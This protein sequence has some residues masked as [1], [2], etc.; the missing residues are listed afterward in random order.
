MNKRL[1]L[2]LLTGFFLFAAVTAGSVCAAGYLASS[3][4]VYGFDF[5]FNNPGARSNAMGGAFVGL[6]DDATAAYANPAGLPVLTL[7]EISIEYKYGKYTSTITEIVNTSPWQATD[8]DFDSTIDGPSFIS[9][10]HP[11]SK[12]TIAVFRHRLVDIK[13]NFIYGALRSS[14]DRFDVNVDIVADTLGLSAGMKIS[15]M[16]NLG[17]SIGFSEMNFWEKTLKYYIPT[18]KLEQ[19]DRVDGSD[20]DIHYTLSMLLSPIDALSVGVY[21]RQ[22][23]GFKFIKNSLSPVLIQIDSD[24]DG[25]LDSFKQTNVVDFALDHEI[26]VPDSYGIGIAYRVSSTL[27]AVLDLNYVE[28]SDLI[29]GMYDQGGTIYEQ[30]F[31]ID[32]ALDLHVGFEYIVDLEATPLALRCGYYYRPAHVFYFSDTTDPFYDLIKKVYPE[33][34]DEHI[35]SL[36]F[37]VLLSHDV[38]FDLA[39]SLGKLTKEA[40]GSL[41]Y[42][43]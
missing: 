17:I 7:P 9:Y 25:V 20:N 27:T 29:D 1:L 15:D 18:G 19:T 11:G 24:N 10:V 39:A 16:V 14:G 37:G 31:S 32:D 33:R 30:S 22:G 28:Y 21:Y 13:T 42:R 26:K 6:A 36:G 40:T 38:Q 12:A 35:Y 5:R 2:W 23:P 4:S 8:V 3:P 41:V 34:E 43:F